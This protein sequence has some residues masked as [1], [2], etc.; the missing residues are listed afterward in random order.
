M[1]LATVTTDQIETTLTDLEARIGACRHLE[2][3]LLVE[4]DQRQVPLSDGAR[5]LAEWVAA[6]LMWPPR[7]PKG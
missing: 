7:R 6:R 3:R 4:L 2:M 5:T 1:E